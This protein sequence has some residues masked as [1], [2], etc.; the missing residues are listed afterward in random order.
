MPQ[1]SPRRQPGGRTATKR[2]PSLV[3]LEELIEL[4]AEDDGH[5]VPI[6]GAARHGG[7]GPPRGLPGVLG[8]PVG[9]VTA[10]RC[11]RENLG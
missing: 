4:L 11:Y 7:G 5:R 1:R 6:L 8:L 9:M 10:R 3:V 2:L